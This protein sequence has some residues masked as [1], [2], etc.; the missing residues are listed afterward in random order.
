[1]TIFFIFLIIFGQQKGQKNADIEKQFLHSIFFCWEAS[2]YQISEKFTKQFEFCQ[3]SSFLVNFGCFFW[4]KNA[5]NKAKERPKSKNCFLLNF[6]LLRII[7]IQNFRKF[8]QTVWILPILL[9]YGQFWLF[10][11]QQRPK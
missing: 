5:N 1:M 4:P 10:F 8:H 6:L 3:F 9:I 2:T 7:Y 11:G